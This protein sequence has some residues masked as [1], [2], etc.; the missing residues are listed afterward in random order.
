MAGVQKEKAAH[1][2]LED[3]DREGVTVRNHGQTPV[4]NTL[5]VSAE[6]YLDEDGGED[7]CCPPVTASGSP[8]PTGP[9]QRS[10]LPTPPCGGVTLG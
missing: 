2:A 9:P 5:L 3:L 8:S 4:T 1:V 10:W 6:V 7:V